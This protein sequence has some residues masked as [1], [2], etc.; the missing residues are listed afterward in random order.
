MRFGCARI[1]DRLRGIEPKRGRLPNGVDNGIFTTRVPATSACFP[2]TS[3][4]FNFEQDLML[5][6]TNSSS[7]KAPMERVLR[8]RLSPAFFLGSLVLVFSCLNLALGARNGTLAMPPIYDDVGYLLDAYQRLE[9]QNVNTPLMLMKSFWSNPPHAPLST[10]TAIIGF[11]LFGPTVWG[12]YVINTWIAAVYA[13]S[14][15][16]VARSNLMVLPSV[17]LVVSMFLVP[18]IHFAMTEF[19][20]DIAAGL[21][22]GLAIYLL[23]ETDYENA[24]KRRQVFVALASAAAIL[25]KPTTFMVTIPFVGLAAIMG[26]FRPGL[27][28]LEGW[29][30]SVLAALFPFGLCMAL[31]IPPAIVLG[32]HTVTYVYQVLIRDRDIWATPADPMLSWTF[33][34]IG[35]GGH[36]ALGNFFYLELVAILIDAGLSAK[37]WREPGAYKAIILYLLVALLYCVMSTSTAQTVFIGSLFFFP[38]LFAAV[39]ALSRILARTAKWAPSSPTLAA[40]ALLIVAVTL[41]PLASIQSDSRAFPGANR[42]LSEISDVVWA[43]ISAN[44]SCQKTPP[45]FAAIA[46]YPITPEAVALSLA[47]QY[48]IEVKPR[49]LFLIRSPDEILERARSADFVLAPNRWGIAIQPNLPGL[50]YIDQTKMALEADPAWKALPISGP[51]APVLY[52]RKVF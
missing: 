34:S 29:R 39:L 43:D 31:L 33:H 6:A 27:H 50:A 10:L 4:G 44:H 3:P 11:S 5:Q 7:Q 24:S 32:P 28:R 41:M 8:N 1:V 16:V 49:Q 12:P 13:A 40:G 25:A 47:F 14:V 23:T 26:I 37:R 9:F 52:L 46:P 38:Y 20:P 18:I 35:I 19:R 2:S 42:M 48:S 15:Y 22:L 45:I 17:M 30:P 51:D 21:L 36:I